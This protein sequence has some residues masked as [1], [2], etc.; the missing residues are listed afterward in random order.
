MVYAV[1]GEM[2][3]Q[4]ASRRNNA[5]NFVVNRLTGENMWGSVEV[6][7]GTDRLS[8]NPKLFCNFRFTTASARDQF[9]TDAIAQLQGVNGPVVGSWIAKHNCSHDEVPPVNCVEGERNTF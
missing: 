5:H 1:I 4:N 6:I 9:Y 3:F 2:A 8:G 7:D